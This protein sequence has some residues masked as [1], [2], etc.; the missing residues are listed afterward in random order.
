MAGVAGKSAGVVGS[1]DLRKPLRLGAVGFMTSRADDGRVELSRLNAG[2]IS[3]L[4]Q[5]AMAGFARDYHVLSR[6]LLVG[7]VGVA[8][9]AS[10]VASVDDGSGGN[11]GDG[12]PA[13]VPVLTKT[14]GDNGCAHNHKCQQHD[15]HHRGKP[16]QM[17]YV[18]K[19]AR[20]S[21]NA[22]RITVSLAVHRISSD[23]R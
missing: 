14:L 2:I 7:D 12:G 11:F 13:V 9:L 20:L 19:Q 23:Q 4:R 17:F 22:I 15:Q 8:S 10:L 18:L 6:L 5:C 16:D 21:G 1:N 3:M